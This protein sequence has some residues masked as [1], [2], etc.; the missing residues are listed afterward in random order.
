VVETSLP[1]GGAGRVNSLQIRL[2]GNERVK[3]WT[4]L[5]TTQCRRGPLVIS[6]DTSIETSVGT[7]KFREATEKPC[8]D[9]LAHTVEVCKGIL[10][11]QQVPGCQ[12]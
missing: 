6:I 5:R 4:L 2:D 3:E 1:I 10:L 7:V 8:S 11:D 9:V 12:G